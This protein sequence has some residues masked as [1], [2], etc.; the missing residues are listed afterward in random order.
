MHWARV[1]IAALIMSA[2]ATAQVTFSKAA[3]GADQSPASAITGDFNKDGKPDFAVVEA[4]NQV[5][6]YLNVGSGKFSRKAQYA[7]ASNDNPIRID[8]ADVNGDGKLDI[9]I[10]KQFVPEFEI[11]NG[12]GDGTFTFSKDVP[13]GS[14][15]NTYDFA[16]ADVNGDGKVDFVLAY[17]DD[18]SSF[19]LTYLN[20]G[21]GNFTQTFGA[22]FTGFATNFVV[23]DFDRDGKPDVLARVDDQLQLYKGTGTGSFTLTK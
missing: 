18:T 20:D 9:V 21:S 1:L 3:Y 17:N 6:I 16:L 5:T 12:N 8:T 4:G 2:L 22:E 15:A 7:I 11:W 19:A 23:A 13:S 10:G 14:V